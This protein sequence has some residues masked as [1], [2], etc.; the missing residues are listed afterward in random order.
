[1]ETRCIKCDQDRMY[2]DEGV[3]LLCSREN[4]PGSKEVKHKDWNI[5]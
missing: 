5:G 1:M 4:Q 2:L 3:C